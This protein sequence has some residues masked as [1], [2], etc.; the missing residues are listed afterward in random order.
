MT[1]ST[2]TEKIDHLLKSD[3]S[4]FLRSIRTDMAN[5]LDSTDESLRQKLG[6]VYAAAIVLS[7]D[8]DQW[9]TFCEQEEWMSFRQR[10]KPTDSHRENALRYAVRY[11]VGFDGSSS[12]QAA[13]RYKKALEGCWI[14]KVAPSEVPNV[15]KESGGIEKLKQ[16]NVQQAKHFPVFFTPNRFTKVIAE[17]GGIGLDAIL[18][19]RFE[20]GGA[21]EVQATILAG[22]ARENGYPSL[23]QFAM[24][25]KKWRAAD[26]KK[27]PPAG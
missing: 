18:L 5:L 10:P 17:R 12:N 21:A 19:V 26:E 4:A 8:K 1:T 20:E 25:F 22:A 27:F 16:Q 2:P 3:A 24:A 6:E 14:R 7:H 13:Y 23:E 11:A 9:Q 15:I